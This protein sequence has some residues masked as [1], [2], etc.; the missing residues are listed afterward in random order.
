MKKNKPLVRVVTLILM[1]FS[2]YTQIIWAI[3]ETH[4]SIQK[5]AV[6]EFLGYFIYS[7]FASDRM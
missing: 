7:Y 1:V 4:D 5:N 3:I 2:L 6:I